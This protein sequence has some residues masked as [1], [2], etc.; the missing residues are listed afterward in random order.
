MFH[1]AVD[2]PYIAARLGIVDPKTILWGS[3]FPH[4]RCTFPNSHAVIRK[5]FGNLPDDVV[6]DITFHNAARLYD[7]DLPDGGR[8]LAAE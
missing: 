6:A 5:A 2:D 8:A 7:I 4:P 3:D 1:G